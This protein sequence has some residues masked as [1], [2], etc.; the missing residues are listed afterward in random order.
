MNENSLLTIF[1]DACVGLRIEEIRCRGGPS[2]DDYDRASMFG[3]AVLSQGDTLLFGGGKPGEAG[4]LA[5]NLA[6]AIA[7]LSFAPGGVG[8]FGRHWESKGVEP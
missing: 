2:T 8:V 7:V 4:D 6:H 1:L 3:R 5:G